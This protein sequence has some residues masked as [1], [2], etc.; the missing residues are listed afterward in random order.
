M[1]INCLQVYSPSLNLVKFQY[2]LDHF[3]R[4]SFCCQ[5]IDW[6]NQK[7]LFSVRVLLDQK[8]LTKEKLESLAREQSWLNLQFKCC[9]DC[10][11]LLTDRYL[12]LPGEYY[13]NG[14]G[15]FKKAKLEKIE[16]GGEIANEEY[17]ALKNDEEN[18]SNNFRKKYSIVTIR[19]TLNAGSCARSHSKP[20]ESD[21]DYF[22]NIPKEFLD[23]SRSSNKPK[24]YKFKPQ[25]INKKLILENVLKEQEKS[26]QILNSFINRKYSR[27]QSESTEAPLEA[28]NMGEMPSRRT[29]EQNSNLSRTGN[30]IRGGSPGQTPP[31]KMWTLLKQISSPPIF[32]PKPPTQSYNLY[33]PRGKSSS[34]LA[35]RLP[36]LSTMAKTGDQVSTSSRMDTID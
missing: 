32:S 18:S 25:P 11:T 33:T 21:R 31:A 6:N 4:G 1:V 29:V 10:F 7:L 15:L 35:A 12:F 14:N 20:K 36:L 13:K 27:F 3:D 24:C 26:H 9:D 8:T 19:N 28:Y 16:N 34:P 23:P 17:S 5:L 30:I 2:L 22:N